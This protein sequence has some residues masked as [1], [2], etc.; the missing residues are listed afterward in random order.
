MNRLLRPTLR[1]S[2]KILFRRAGS[3]SGVTPP[4]ARMAPPTSSVR[5]LSFVFVDSYLFK[6]N[7]LLC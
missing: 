4:F 5:C 2:K 3:A 7:M 1:T 6:C